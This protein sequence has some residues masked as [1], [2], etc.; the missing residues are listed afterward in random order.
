MP[1][2]IHRA[3]IMIDALDTDSITKAA[4]LRAFERRMELFGNDIYFFNEPFTPI[5]LTGTRCALKC[6]HCNSHY[7]RH[8]LDGSNNKL[9]SHA[10]DLAN[11]GANGILLSGG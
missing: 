2:D 9:F 6:K 10:I 5:S 4:M 3:R 1:C 7:L 11:K 8:M